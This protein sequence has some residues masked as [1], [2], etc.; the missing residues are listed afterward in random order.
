MD[1][2]KN[3]DKNENNIMDNIEFIMSRIVSIILIICLGT[4]VCSLINFRKVESIW[5]TKL[6]IAK[7]QTTEQITELPKE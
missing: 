5:E 7:L 2:N 6:E 3:I 1:K 4:I